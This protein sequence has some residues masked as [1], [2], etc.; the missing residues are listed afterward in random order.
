MTSCLALPDIPLFKNACKFAETDATAVDDVR[1]GKTYSYRDLVYAAAKL[2]QQLLR[3]RCDLK[4]ERVGVLCPSGFAYVVCQWATWAAGGVA[5]P[6]CT[7]HPLAE[8]QYAV[9]EA[10]V[11]HFIGHSVFKDRVQE[12]VKGTDGLDIMLLEDQDFNVEKPVIPERFPMDMD[13]PALIIF[14]SGTTGKPKGAV[15]THSTIDAQASVLVDA[16]RW[17]SSD[18]IHHILPLHHVHG[19]IN[20]LTCALYCGATVEMHQKFDAAQVWSRWQEGYQK[21]APLLTLFMSVPTVYAK[22]IQHYKSLEPKDQQSCSASCQQFRLMVSGSASLPTPL[23]ETWR[24]ISSGQVLLERYGMTEIGM[25]LS[26]GYD[27]GERVE[28]TVGMPL[29]GVHVRLMD[30]SGQNVTDSREVPGML[31][32]KGR[33]VFKEYW[34]RPEATRKEFTDDGWFITG[35]MAMRVSEKG[36]YQILGRASIDIIKSGGEKVSALEVERELLSCD[37]G[38]HDAAVVGIPDPEWGQRVAAVVVMDTGKKLDLV[39]LRNVLKARLASYKV[40]TRLKTVAELPKN[41]MGK[42]TKNGLLP[43]FEE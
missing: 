11:T 32:I 3:D 29:P 38:I 19:I 17:S 20:A 43:L 14:T 40:P 42:V 35:D 15:T 2:R 7:S 16:W 30:E 34:Q 23:R 6:L 28:G 26:Q 25:A 9:E 12:L 1:V 13:K 8:Q 10:Q 5:V 39:T 33:N 41:A 37:L 4:G 21:T 36:Y 31:Q 24:K 18:R 22:L 27:L